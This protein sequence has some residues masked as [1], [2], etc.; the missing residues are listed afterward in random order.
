MDIFLKVTAGILIAA[1]VCLVLS[2][3]GSE[4]ALLL[5]IAVCCMVVTA[6]FYYLQ[7]VLDFATKLI[8]IGKIDRDILGVLLRVVGIGLI[9]QVAGLI[10]TDAGNHSLGKAL[11]ILT[12]VVIL[13]ISVP[14]L[15]Q[16]LS[17]IE[18]ILGGV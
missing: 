2:R 3:Q 4:I 14:I 13:C 7:P 10:C 8:E 18:S 17:L 12:T 16:M 15:E 6:A 1:I 9:S 5:T 11:Q